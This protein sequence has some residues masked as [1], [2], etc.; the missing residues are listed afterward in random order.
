MSEVLHSSIFTSPRDVFIAS[1]KNPS[2]FWKNARGSVKEGFSR[3]GFTPNRNAP[4]TI[5]V[6]SHNETFGKKA[7]HLQACLASLAHLS[8]PPDPVHVVVIGHNNGPDDLS[9]KLCDEAGV[10]YF[11]FDTPLRGFSYP[12]QLASVLSDQFIGIVDADTTVPQQWLNA[13][14]GTLTLGYF[15]SAG[16]RRYLAHDGH[17][18]P[19]GTIKTTGE[20]L[21]WNAGK[22]KLVS[23]NSFYAPGVL[24]SAVTPMLGR[25]VTDGDIQR[26]IE[27]TGSVG[28]TYDTLAYSDGEKFNISATQLPQVL[29]QKFRGLFGR[30]TEEDSVRF[31]QTELPS[32]FPQFKEHLTAHPAHTLQELLKERELFEQEIIPQATHEINRM[33]K[34]YAEQGR[35]KTTPLI[36]LL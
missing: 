13:H 30:Y 3:D 10:D 6:P 27:K 4:I 1:V 25:M 24:P 29:L 16:P 14:L 23:G 20:R 32:Y 2:D 35:G 33:K 18:I 21:L 31:L 17:V 26:E 36:A 34:L 8:L 11:P 19:Y 22:T 12:L 9:E 5:V 15:A 7:G 28:F